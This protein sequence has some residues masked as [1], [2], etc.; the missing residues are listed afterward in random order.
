MQNF[1]SL[2]PIGIVVKSSSSKAF[3]ITRD[4]KYTTP[5]TIIEAKVIIL[6]SENEVTSKAARP[7][8][9]EEI[10]GLINTFITLGT[11]PVNLIKQIIFAKKMNK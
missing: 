10:N 11:T 4:T 5:A 9:T 8:S 1:T 2:L 6:E 3:N 7:H